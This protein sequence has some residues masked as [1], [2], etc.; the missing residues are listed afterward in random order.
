[1]E[2]IACH[3]RV[4]NHSRFCQT[5]GERQLAQTTAGTKDIRLAQPI[6]R[7]SD[8]KLA[9]TTPRARDIRLE[10]VVPRLIVSIGALLLGVAA[11][12]IWMKYSASTSSAVKT[13]RQD[14]KI[15]EQTKTQSDQ[16]RNPATAIEAR[17]EEWVDDPGKEPGSADE[18]KE[19]ESESSLVIPSVPPPPPPPDITLL[20]TTAAISSGKYLYYGFKISPGYSPSSHVRGNFSVQ[21]EAGDI[22]VS[23]TDASGLTNLARGQEDKGL[24]RSGKTPQGRIDLRLRPGQYYLIVDNRGS[25][26]SNKVRVELKLA[27]DDS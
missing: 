17:K 27:R 26:V 10:R 22:S 9:R 25:R 3:D 23:I 14:Q 16:S 21:G 20:S 4:P 6:A 8:I 18:G 12:I 11:L 19:T 13:T 2:C 15:T 24:Y 7:V 1:M 5:C